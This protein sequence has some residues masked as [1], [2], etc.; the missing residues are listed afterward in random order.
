MD[1]D[2]HILRL[3][4]KKGSNFRKTHAVEFYVYF[5]TKASAKK[6]S[7]LIRALGFHVELLSDPSGKRWICLSIRELLPK[8]KTIHG[9]KTKLDRLS[10]PLGGHCDSWGTQIEK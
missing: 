5:P 2:R 7:L 3:L 8:Y 10:K 4:R 9:F 1:L 6:A